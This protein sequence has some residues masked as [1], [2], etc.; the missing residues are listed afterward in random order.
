MVDAG[1]IP[2]LQHQIGTFW[3]HQ[4]KQR[5]GRR[6]SWQRFVKDQV[7]S[8]RALLAVIPADHQP[9]PKEAGVDARRRQRIQSSWERRC[10]GRIE[11]WRE[12]GFTRTERIKL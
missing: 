6:L 7:S 4:V 10:D 2:A 8:L 12:H 3:Q 5:V 9:A 1:S 11:K